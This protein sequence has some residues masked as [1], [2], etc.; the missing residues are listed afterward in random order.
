MEWTLL[1]QV[2]VQW[3]HIASTTREELLKDMRNCHN[4]SI[5]GGIKERIFLRGT[6]HCDEDIQNVRITA[7]KHNYILLVYLWSIMR[8]V[9]AHIQKPIIRLI[10]P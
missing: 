9:L 7:V 6:N 4:L 5:Q 1:A 3:R 10:N 8:N 2:M